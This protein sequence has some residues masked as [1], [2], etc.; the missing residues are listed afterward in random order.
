[1]A[2]PGVTGI[3]GLATVRLG[4]RLATAG[5]RAG[6]VRLGLMTAG[7]AL[8]VALLLGVAGVGPALAN[9][10]ARLAAQAPYCRPPATGGARFSG[11][12]GQAAACQAVARAPNHLEVLVNP[13]DSFRGRPLTRVLVAAVGSPAGLGRPPGVAR[14][15]GPGQLVVSPALARLLGSPGGNLL[16]PRLA[17]RVTGTIGRS[18]LV[19]PGELLAYMGSKPPA[20]PASG[21]WQPATGFGPPPSPPGTRQ[22]PVLS[23]SLVLFVVLGSVV[24]LAP[25]LAFII[26]ATRLSA[27][28]RERRLATLRLLGATPAQVRLLLAT[29]AGLAAVTGSIAGA[30]LLV[31]GRQLLPLVLPGVLMVFP[32]ELSPKPSV[33]LAVLVVVPVL[34][35]VAGLVSLRRVELTPLGVQRRARHPRERRAGLWRLAPLAL[36]FAGLATMVGYRHAL[37][38][39]NHFLLPRLS[40]AG[41]TLLVVV[42]VIVAGPWVGVVLAG[43]LA[44]RTRSA[45][46]LLG[47]RR[48]Q[49]EPTSTARIAGG[50][51]VVAFAATAML[52]L[53][54]Y[55][56]RVPASGAPASPGL[57]V[58]QSAHPTKPFLARLAGLAGV[59]AV[60]PVESLEAAG[61]PTP[62][63]PTAGAAVQ[64]WTVNVV[65][66]AGMHL[67]L[68]ARAPHCSAGAPA[69]FYPAGQLQVSP[70]VV[71]PFVEQQT[72]ATGGQTGTGAPPP[73]PGARP[74][75]PFPLPARLAPV[76]NLAGLS[77]NSIDGFGYGLM[78]TTSAVPRSVW[79]SMLP[80]SLTTVV[81]STHSW[82]A[83]QRV[84]DLVAA[85]SPG[86]YVMAERQIVSVSNQLQHEVARAVDVGLALVLVVASAGLLIETLDAL[87]ER[88]RPLAVLAATG[89][90]RRTLAASVVVAT[91][92][93]LLGAVALAEAAALGAAALF[94]LLV[95]AHLRLAI[96]PAAMT[97]AGGLA[98]VALVTL[99]TLPSVAMSHAAEGLRAD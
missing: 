66:C 6:V 29:E 38:A 44:R 35:L 51:A 96:V 39:S 59:G 98:G 12:T 9:H 65:S 25:V 21:G 90:S 3:G 91:G 17:G 63:Q 55:F 50:V 67:V 84:R 34:A 11:Y 93:P 2:G 7:V 62:G 52:E 95:L 69:G 80:S 92:L 82:R 42:G 70:S 87:A 46:A 61:Q 89:V 53:A 31:A 85:R 49:L 40:L 19:Y 24:V 8:G 28:T 81:V 48:L 60:V 23:A 1:M 68:G 41:S 78:L 86:A 79:A 73:V 13:G 94:Q 77:T 64:P 88:R 43:P 32:S 75:A 15:P 14:L 22:S 99:A 56:D 45:G 47:A 20:K 36:G 97:A 74:F 26:T 57:M 37:S 27:A 16:R 4:L 54:P 18:G 5:G 76:P 30:G 58:V 72:A 83:R 71:R 10:E 33:V